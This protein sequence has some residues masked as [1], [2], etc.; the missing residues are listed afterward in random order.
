M[1]YRGL[2][3]GVGDAAPESLHHKELHYFPWFE[4]CDEERGRP[5]IDGN[6]SI[7]TLFHGLFGGEGRAGGFIIIE[8]I[9]ISLHFQ[10]CLMRG[11]ARAAPESL[12]IQRY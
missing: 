7:S 10:I 11:G 8:N 6:T 1:H 9:M 2:F 3:G 4:R 12:K 5:R